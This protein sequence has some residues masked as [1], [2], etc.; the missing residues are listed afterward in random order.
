MLRALIGVEREAQLLDAA[1]A[2]KL[3][4][5][6]QIDHQTP[7]ARVCAQANDVVDGIAID[8]FAHREMMSDE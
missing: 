8:A 6:D 1:Q 3:W 2:L 7:L 4:R 5:V